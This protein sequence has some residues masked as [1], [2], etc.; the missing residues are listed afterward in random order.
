[1]EENHVKN[2]KKKVKM[3]IIS[4]ICCIFAPILEYLFK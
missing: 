1:M 3:H 4:K 2:K